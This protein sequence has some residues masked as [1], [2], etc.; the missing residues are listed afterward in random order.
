MTLL[1]F[2]LFA[3]PLIVGIAGWVS[4]RWGTAAGGW[5]AGLPV[6]T[7]PISVFLFVEYG[8]DFSI[9]AALGTL[10]AMPAIAATAA[11]YRMAVNFGCGWVSSQAT[12]Q[13]CYLAMA[14]FLA[15]FNP[16]PLLIFL[17]SMGPIIAG[18]GLAGSS[19]RSPLPAFSSN[20]VLVMRLAVTTAL[21]LVITVLAPMLGPMLSGLLGTVLIVAGVLAAA[22]PPRAWQRGRARGDAR[23]DARADCVFGVLFCC[24]EFVT[25]VGFCHLPVGIGRGWTGWCRC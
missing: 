10:Y 17:L 11:G 9:Q 3:T 7:G 13:G 16:D 18:L 8:A 21:V 22:G 2:K 19:S 1:L 14:F 6:T 23:H 15:L 5:V 20:T 25:A 24:L 12:A 4:R